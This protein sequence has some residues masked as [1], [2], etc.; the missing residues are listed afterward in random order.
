MGLNILPP[1]INQSEIKYTGK[2]GEIRVGLMQLKD[3]SREAKEAV[4]HERAKNG[5]FHSLDNFLDRTGTRIQ[6]QDARVLIKAGCFDSIAQGST[7]PALMWQ[8]L[9][10]FREERQERELSLFTPIKNAGSSHRTPPN[11]EP[12]PKSIMARHEVET[13]GFFLSIHP[14]DRCRDF[15]RGVN[16]VK[17][18]DLHD[19]VGRH[20][21]TIGWQVT[22]KTVHTRGGEPMKFVSFEDP[23]GI[24]ET[25]FFPKAYNQFCHLLN[26]M[27]PYI[28]KGRVEEDCGA[29]NI[30][31]N[32]IGFLDKGKG[33]N[34]PV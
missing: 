11:R 1:D 2:G 33:R 22:G 23:T 15:L 13:L 14:I 16:Y 21:T 4:V 19:W 30:T 7:R 20:V 10:F 31:V 18:R 28:L 25:V 32:W 34:S 29:I 8:A 9:R 27:R 3:L 24:Y 26:K 5:P 6:L 12:Y 17:A